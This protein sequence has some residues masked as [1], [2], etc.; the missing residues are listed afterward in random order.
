M[1][2]AESMQLRPSLRKIKSIVGRY[3][4]ITIVFAWLIVLILLRTYV[5]AAISQPGNL[6]YN[7]PVVSTIQGA[8]KWDG[9]YYLQIIRQGYDFSGPTAVFYPIFPL[10]VGLLSR[11]GL[12]IVISAQIV[13]ALALILASQGLYLLTILVTKKR[14]IA[15]LA[16][17]A[18]LAFPVAHFFIAFYT[19]ALFSA[20]VVW[21]LYFLLRKKYI[22]A[23]VLAGF[24]TGTRGAGVVLGLVILIQYLA[25][26]GWS[27][28][29]IDWQI[30]AVPI[31]FFGIAAYWLWIYR[32][33]KIL[34]WV[35]FSGL[36]AKFWPY[37]RFESNI[38]KTLYVELLSMVTLINSTSWMDAWLSEWFTKLHFFVAWL[39]I[40]YSAWLGWVK[41]LPL[42]LVLYSALTALMLI[43]TGN[44]VSHSRYILPVFPV[45]ILIA[46]WLDKQAEWVRTLYFVASAIALGAMLTLF[47]NGYWV[48]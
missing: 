28:R 8:V 29:K 7:P 27:W 34:P 44:F 37:M 25:D 12:G 16:V 35:F 47:S 38:L 15:L 42:A 3:P 39:T 21:S 14:Q 23:G 11:L 20:L 33:T 2:K 17:L 1:H 40:V 46:M 9:H 48:G 18:W 36:Y 13:N 32:E 22:W 19:E 31:S 26:K 6:D 24:A 10:I 5:V 43:L 30:L 45:F 4:A 41:K